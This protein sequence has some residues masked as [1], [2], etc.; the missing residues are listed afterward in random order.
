[1]VPTGTAVNS[2]TSP[3]A[4]GHGHVAEP[5]DIQARRVAPCS[6]VTTVVSLLVIAITE[7]GVSYCMEL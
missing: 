6:V 1:M 4:V 7:R 3:F 5:S 2:T